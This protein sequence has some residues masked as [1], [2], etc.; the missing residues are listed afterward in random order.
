[1]HSIR[2]HH[3]A[4][5]RGHGQNEWLDTYHSFSF[6]DFYD[7]SRMG[8]GT[9]LVINDDTISGGHGFGFHSH[10]D[11]E[12]ITIPLEGSLTHRDS[13]GNEGTIG[14]GEVQAMSAG[15]GVIHSE[16]NASATDPVTLF[17][18]WITPSVT[19]GAA[20]YAQ[21]AY[22]QGEEVVLVSPDGGG[23]SLVIQQD[24]WISMYTKSTGE[25][26][27]YTPRREGN[28]VYVFV[29]S[30]N[31]LMDGVHLEERDAY[32]VSSEEVVDISIGTTAKLLIFD[33]PMETR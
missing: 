7:P 6:A 20:R 1:M 16:V 28:G 3:R 12:I 10:Q 26:V 31:V 18:I 23:G 17:Q 5:E 25:K 21:Q 22:P 15:E 32:G 33:V 29:V 4:K 9:L 30:G 27:A 2:V 14:P 19:G 13:M 24:A 8:F 11:M